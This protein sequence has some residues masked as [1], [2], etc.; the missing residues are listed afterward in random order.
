MLNQIYYVK[1]FGYG[2]ANGTTI[3]SGRF[4]PDVSAR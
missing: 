2:F 3:F 4:A 1:I